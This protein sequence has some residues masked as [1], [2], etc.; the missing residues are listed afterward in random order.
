MFIWSFNILFLTM[1]KFLLFII[2]ICIRLGYS[3]SNCF[4]SFSNFVKCF[5]I[6]SLTSSIILDLVFL[7]CKNIENSID[8][9]AF[10]ICNKFLK[11]LEIR[12]NNLF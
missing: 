2:L 1:S 7:S 12:I 8:E 10:I 3:F 5:W 4:N 6:F 11:S 9:T